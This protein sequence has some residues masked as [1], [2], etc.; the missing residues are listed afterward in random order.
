M[1][2]EVSDMKKFLVPFLTFVL[3]LTACGTP[4]LY[5]LD[6]Y[7]PELIDITTQYPYTEKI[8]VTDCSTG[9]VREY[10]DGEMHDNIRMHFEGIQCTRDKVKENA[11]Y[12]PLYE[13]TFYATDRTTAVTVLSDSAYLIGEYRYDAITSGVDLVYLANLFAE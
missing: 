6:D 3:F 5:V 1:N 10:T 8:T 11:V 12:T 7:I 9:D 2:D 13:V 4:G